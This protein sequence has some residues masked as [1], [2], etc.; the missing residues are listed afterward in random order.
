MCF[1]GSTY[2][3]KKLFVFYENFSNSKMKVIVTNLCVDKKNPKR[4][5]WSDTAY[6]NHN[7]VYV[8][9]S[10]NNL[11]YMVFDQSNFLN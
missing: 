9:Q 8:K 11:I 4:K 5:I 7:E 10:I 2:T 1:K 3:Q 6:C